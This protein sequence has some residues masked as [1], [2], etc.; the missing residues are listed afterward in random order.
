MILAEQ[1]VQRRDAQAWDAVMDE[2]LT[3]LPVRIVQSTTDQGR[4][5]LKHGRDSLHAHH[6]PDLFHVLRDLHKATSRP[7]AK[8]QKATHARLAEMTRA[9]QDVAPKRRA[10]SRQSGAPGASWTR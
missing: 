8:R 1:Y 9:R 10:S 6:S 3:A 4:A 5:L 2:A 7:L